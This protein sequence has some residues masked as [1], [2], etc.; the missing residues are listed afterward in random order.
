MKTCAVIGHG[1][2]VDCAIPGLLIGKRYAYLR[3]VSLTGMFFPI[4][5]KSARKKLFRSPVSKIVAE[6]ME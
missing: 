3:I 5:G 6:L 4:H 1:M 2:V